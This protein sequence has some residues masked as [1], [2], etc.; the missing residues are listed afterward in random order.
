[1]K[2]PY[3]F[4]LSMLIVV[5]CG[6]GG[7]SNNNA[8]I[9]IDNPSISFFTSSAS[10]ITAGESVTLNWS[11]SNTNSCYASGDWSESILTNGH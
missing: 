1:M 6:G 4:I 5:S 2:T 3:I 10:T 11:S 9:H 8:P 7:S